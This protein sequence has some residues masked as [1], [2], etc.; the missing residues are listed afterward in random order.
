MSTRKRYWLMKSEPTDFSIDD[1]AR[2]GTEPWTGVRNYQARN[3]MR[4]MQ[5]GDGVLFYHSNTE[6]PGIYGLAEVAS[7]AYP[8]PTQFE[9][10]SK[11]F[12]P[13]ATREQ[14]RWELVDVRFVRRLARPVTL[15]EI[16]GHADA[17]GEEF[18]LIRK[19]SRLSVMPVT[20]AQWKLLVGLEKT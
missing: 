13:K 20:A 4:Q 1:L 6:V 10:K 8:D 18:A 14:P 2:V 7:R 5:V 11:Y 15:E 17:L 16:R 9:K 12:D 19:G 3:F